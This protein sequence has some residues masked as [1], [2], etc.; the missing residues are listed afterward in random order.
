MIKEAISIFYNFSKLIFLVL[1]VALIGRLYFIQPYA[2]DGQSMEPNLHDKDILIVERW[3]YYLDNPRRGDIVV[4]YPPRQAGRATFVKRIIGLPG[5]KV[6]LNPQGIMINGRRLIEEYLSPKVIAR[7]FRGTTVD[8]ETT[9]ALKNDEYFLLGDNREHSQ[10]S[11]NF[12]VI[13]KSAIVGKVLVVA[14]PRASF[15]VVAAPAY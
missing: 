11:R 8:Q 14:L 2:T 9:A 5:E 12:G 13:S 10:D 4:F 6:T 15:R 1:L 7:T 3:S